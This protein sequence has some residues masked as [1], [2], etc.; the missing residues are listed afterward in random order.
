VVCGPTFCSAD[1]LA[2]DVTV[3]DNAHLHH[4]RIA[5]SLEFDLFQ[6]GRCVGRETHEDSRVR[7]RSGCRNL[8]IWMSELLHC[9][10][11][12]AKRKRDLKNEHCNFW[13]RPTLPF[14][15]KLLTM[16][17]RSTHLEVPEV[18]S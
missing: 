11:A 6:R 7:C 8:T 2:C 9:C 1:Q 18:E 16:C 14:G 13:R 4:V 10:G 3:L 17:Q 5:V 15:R 12:E